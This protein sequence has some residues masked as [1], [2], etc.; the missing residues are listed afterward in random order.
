MQKDVF[1]QGDFAE[2][3]LPSLLITWPCL[4]PWSCLV[5]LRLSSK[6]RL[7]LSHDSRHGHHFVDIINQLSSFFVQTSVIRSCWISPVWVSIRPNRIQSLK[8][9]HMKDGAL[10]CDVRLLQKRLI[11]HYNTLF[12]ICVSF[13]RTIIVSAA[14]LLY[15]WSNVKRLE[16]ESNVQT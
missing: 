14:E 5:W 15:R 8:A 10:H 16:A 2:P 9:V 13:R 1:D 3:S 7:H 4:R 11:M 12:C 6:L